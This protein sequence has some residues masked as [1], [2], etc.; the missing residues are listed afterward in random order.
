MKGLLLFNGKAVIPENRD[1]YRQLFSTIF[2]DYFLFD[3]LVV[4]AGGVSTS[5]A[6]YLEKLEIAHKVRVENDCFST[7]DLSA[8]QRKRLAL[9]QVYLEGRPVIV[10]DEWAAEQDPTSSPVLYRDPSRVGIVLD[11][12]AIPT[13]ALTPRRLKRRQGRLM[14]AI[15]SVVAAFLDRARVRKSDTLVTEEVTRGD[16][17]EAV[18]ATGK[19]E[20]RTFV[21][22]GAQASG[23]LFKACGFVSPVLASENL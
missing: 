12:S 16:L 10:F 21:D 5:V 1:D 6:L 14:L 7:T 2:F 22:V 8:G 23:Q 15:G 11:T 17:E 20:P 9:V 4:P 13:A 19:I 18:T 3:D